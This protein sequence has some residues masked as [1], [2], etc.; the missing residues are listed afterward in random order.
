[1]PHVVRWQIDPHEGLD[2]S[3]AL[4]VLRRGHVLDLAA[5]GR[6]REPEVPAP[7]DEASRTH[8]EACL[9]LAFEDAFR[10]AE[11]PAES[12]TGEA[13]SDS[14]TGT[15]APESIASASPVPDAMGLATPGLVARHPSRRRPLRRLPGGR[16]LVRGA[17]L[18]RDAARLFSELF[19]DDHIE[20]VPAVNYLNSALWTRPWTRVGTLS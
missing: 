11:Q 1:M 18:L 10:I 8:A 15:T 3:Q 14:I 6:K 5:N 4:Q 9:R 13:A 12:R 2:V 17:R 7:D 16:I 19:H 20:P